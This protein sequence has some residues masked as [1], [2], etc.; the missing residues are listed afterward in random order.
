GTL[1]GHRLC[2]ACLSLGELAQQLAL[3]WRRQIQRN[4]FESPTACP[5]TRASFPKV[6][7]HSYGKEHPEEKEPH[8]QVDHRASTACLPE[9]QSGKRHPYFHGV[10][11][12]CHPPELCV[13]PRYKL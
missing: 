6:V 7:Q 5:P 9:E 3:L 2:E 13:W 8:P 11:P 1:R 12:A 10:Q 4:S